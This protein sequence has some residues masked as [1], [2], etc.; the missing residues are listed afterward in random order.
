MTPCFVMA[1]MPSPAAPPT[2]ASM[3]VS[4]YKTVSKGGSS[5]GAHSDGEGQARQQEGAG[6]TRPTA[7]QPAGPPDATA[8]ANTTAAAQPPPVL[9]A[10]PASRMQ[11]LLGSCLGK[12]MGACGPCAARTAVEVTGAH[13][14]A[15]HSYHT[16]GG[17][18]PIWVHTRKQACKNTGMQER[19]NAGL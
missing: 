5:E 8:R 13:G 6:V 10:A 9:P 18:R 11:M 12:A 2:D 17:G 1:R 15:D 16:D 3:D 7:A 19:S 4:D 14:G